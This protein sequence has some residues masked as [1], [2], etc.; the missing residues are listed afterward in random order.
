MEKCG[1]ERQKLMKKEGKNVSSATC[2]CFAISGWTD[3]SMKL[4]A[5]KRIGLPD[6]YQLSVGGFLAYP[7]EASALSV[8]CAQCTDMTRNYASAIMVQNH[9]V[10]L[11]ARASPGNIPT[12]MSTHQ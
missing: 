11:K 3:K 12:M 5:K 8:K 1:K 10:C 7:L 2:Y 4:G 6:A 9:T